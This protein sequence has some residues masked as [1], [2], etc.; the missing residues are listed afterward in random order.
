V[1]DILLIF[2]GILFGLALYFGIGYGFAIFLEEGS[3]KQSAIQYLVI[4]LTWP[5]LVTFLC[6]CL[7]THDIL[8]FLA[9]RNA[10]KK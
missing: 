4:T 3:K 5:L 10:S 2:A 9:R 1:V 6:A 7:L 8:E